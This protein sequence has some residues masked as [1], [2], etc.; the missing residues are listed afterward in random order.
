MRV[1]KIT[2]GITEFRYPTGNS[3]R[4]EVQRVCQFIVFSM[5]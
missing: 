2:S 5:A 1:T 4:N 3:V